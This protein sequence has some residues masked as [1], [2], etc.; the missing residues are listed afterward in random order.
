RVLV[1]EDN[2]VN[3]LVTVGMVSRMGLAVDAAA[4]GREAIA[5]LEQHD[6]DLV[7]MDC[8]MPDMDGYA[9]TRHVRDPASAVRNHRVPII[10]L[11]ANALEGDRE[12]CLDA[13]MDDHIGKPIRLEDLATALTR[14]IRRR[15][16][17]DSA[18]G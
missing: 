6:Y 4:T 13:G 12:R 10:A 2:A 8:Q 16:P 3:Q 14:W 7:L 9:A 5:R 18:D 15:D 1:V 11:T 17:A